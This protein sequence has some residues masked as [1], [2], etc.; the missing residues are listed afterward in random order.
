[1][2]AWLVKSHFVTGNC[3]HAPCMVDCQN[4]VSAQSRKYR[5]RKKPKVGTILTECLQ[6]LFMEHSTTDQV[7]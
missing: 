7:I 2:L 3:D 5:D 1:M 4:L 6:E